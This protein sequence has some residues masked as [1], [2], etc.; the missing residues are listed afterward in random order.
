MTAS[1]PAFV[2]LVR[3]HGVGVVLTDKDDVSAD[4]RRHRALRLCAAAE[5]PEDVATGYAPK[6]L[7]LWA[8]R[9]AAWARGGAPADLDC[10]GPAEKKPPKSRDVF[11]YM[12]NGFKPKAP[13]A[14]M[15]MIERVGAGAG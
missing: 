3:G 15:A 10:V 5:T 1:T 9:A 2:A 8:K 14:A 12:I 7:D 13:A 11:V 4:R 6:A